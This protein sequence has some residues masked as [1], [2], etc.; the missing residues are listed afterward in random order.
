MNLPR[1]ASNAAFNVLNPVLPVK[2]KAFKRFQKINKIIIKQFAE[3]VTE[4]EINK[5]SNQFP[6]G[7]YL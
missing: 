4:V 5:M 2:F 1:S 7:N 3:E 6:F